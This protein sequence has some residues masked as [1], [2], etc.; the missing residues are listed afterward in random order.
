MTMGSGVGM[1]VHAPTVSVDVR[2][3][4]RCGHRFKLAQRSAA[5]PRRPRSCPGWLTALR[6]RR[7]Q[8]RDHRPRGRQCFLL[9]S[10][11]R[12]SPCCRP[13]RWP[14]D[15][16]SAGVLNLQVEVDLSGSPKSQVCLIRGGIAL[17]PAAA[18]PFCD[19]R[20]WRRASGYPLSEGKGRVPCGRVAVHGAGTL[21]WAAAHP[22]LARHQK[23]ES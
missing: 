22:S 9:A 12:P 5:V 4:S 18:F 16:T 15:L 19:R 21:A 7:S 23:G 11:L 13:T 1:A 17:L 2:V 14:H 10:L 3:D 8:V 6:R 20:R